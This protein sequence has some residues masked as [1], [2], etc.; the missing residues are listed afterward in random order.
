VTKRA[1]TSASYFWD[2]ASASTSV[3]TSINTGYHTGANITVGESSMRIDGANASG[4]NHW[5]VH[6]VAD[7]EL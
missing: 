4:N 1:V 3:I 6:F 5:Q 2:A 7:A